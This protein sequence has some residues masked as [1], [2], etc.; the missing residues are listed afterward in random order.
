[1]NNSTMIVNILHC[2]NKVILFCNTQTSRQV[3][4]PSSHIQGGPFSNFTL[5]V[6][7]L[8]KLKKIIK[9]CKRYLNRK[10]D[11]NGSVK[12]NSINKQMK[13]LSNNH[14]HVVFFDHKHDIK[15]NMRRFDTL[16]RK[17]FIASKLIDGFCWYFLILIWTHSM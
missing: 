15:Q 11:Q 16:L 13:K 5:W 8:Q 12:M 6:S 2:I 14:Y 17:F 3:F 10:I 9:I 1:M 7:I 4:G